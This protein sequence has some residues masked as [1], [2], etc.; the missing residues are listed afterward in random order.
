MDLIGAFYKGY[1]AGKFDMLNEI[2]DVLKARES[3]IRPKEFNKGFDEVC[4]VASTNLTAEVP[5]IKQE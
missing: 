4:Q 2:M 3:D 5:D 1:N